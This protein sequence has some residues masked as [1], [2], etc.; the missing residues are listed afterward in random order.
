MTVPTLV[1]QLHEGLHI[2]IRSYKYHEDESD[3]LSF[4][5]EYHMPGRHVISLSAKRYPLSESPMLLLNAGITQP[6]RSSK[7]CGKL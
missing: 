5:Y 3:H 2:L 7:S 6:I 1:R 4:T